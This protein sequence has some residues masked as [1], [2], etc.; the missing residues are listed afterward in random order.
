MPTADFMT[1]DAFAR[2]PRGRLRWWLHLRRQL[3]HGVPG[4]RW[5]SI[6]HSNNATHADV[7]SLVPGGCALVAAWDDAAAAEAAFRG[8]LRAAIAGP[9]LFSLDGEVVRV[10]VDA[11]SERD[12][13]HGWTPSSEGTEP[14]TADEPVVVVVHGILH[15]P[16]LARFVRNNFHAASRAV[17]HPGHR[18]SIDISSDLP[19]E[20][21]S[22]SLWKT[23]ALAKDFAYEPGGHSMALK[24]ALKNKTHRVGVFLQVRP[25]ASS[26]TL[27]IGKPAFP[28]LPPARRGAG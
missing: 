8:P 10:R 15:P 28:T 4:L 22:V 1:I 24:H 5:A 3:R 12:H 11:G 18:G 27:G 17:H 19:F 14:L 6:N 20:H 21:T 25:L 23:Y 26:G 16:A 2:P 9:P 7:P 13:W